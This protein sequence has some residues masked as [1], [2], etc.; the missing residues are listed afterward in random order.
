M[1]HRN[2]NNNNLLKTPSIS[3]RTAIQ[4][5]DFRTVTF[6]I[7]S[8]F[9]RL[10]SRVTPCIKLLDPCKHSFLQVEFRWTMI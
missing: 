1:Q 9:R 10:S 5:L 7:I 6:Q 3:V 8:L 4:A 2:R